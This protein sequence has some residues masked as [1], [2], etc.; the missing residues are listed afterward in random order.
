MSERA[1]VAPWRGGKIFLR[2]GGAE[3][4]TPTAETLVTA[5]IRLY[6]S[7]AKAPGRTQAGGCLS[8]VTE[9]RKF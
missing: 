7:G 4:W 3:T 9:P 8:R 2:R 1:C 6:P 5:L